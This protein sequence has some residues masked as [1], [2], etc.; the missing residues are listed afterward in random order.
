MYINTNFSSLF[1][2]LCTTE[3]R[4]LASCHKNAY[5]LKR[6]LLVKNLRLRTLLV[7]RRM[8]L[9]FQRAREKKSSTKERKKQ[10]KKRFLGAASYNKKRKERDEEEREDS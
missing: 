3:V 6:S 2:P 4:F 1:V 8:D 7:K 10:T 5:E 9:F